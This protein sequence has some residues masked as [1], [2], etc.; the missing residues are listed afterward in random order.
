LFSELTMS[1]SLPTG[2]RA[3]ILAAGLCALLPAGTPGTQVLFQ[4]KHWGE[5]EIMVPQVLDGDPC[6]A[7]L[8]FDDQ[9]AAGSGVSARKTVT[10]RE[11]GHLE[12]SFD[13]T[14]LGSGLD[15]AVFE[16]PLEVSVTPDEPGLPYLYRV[17]R[18]SQPQDGLQCR[19]RM[20]PAG[21]AKGEARGESKREAKE[22][23]KHTAR[24]AGAGAGAAP[25]P[26]AFEFKRF[27][28]P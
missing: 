21:E 18:W 9:S 22:E 15:E 12:V 25:G 1:R 14:R 19:A 17:G 20:E 4:N 24:G 28:A 5:V 11:M 13:F 16:I 8:H 2:A 27:P 6:L 10:V 26:V 7:R 3:L 23:T